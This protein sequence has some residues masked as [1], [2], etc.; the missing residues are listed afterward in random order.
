MQPKKEP[1]MH[2]DERDDFIAI[3][4]QHNL[5]ESDFEIV[6]L[7]FPYTKYS[8]DFGRDSSL[9]FLYEPDEISGCA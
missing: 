4:S 5:K 3:I 8:S 6:E 9:K 7:F 1:K 2:T